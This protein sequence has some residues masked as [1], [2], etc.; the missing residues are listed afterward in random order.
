MRITKKFTGESSIGKRVFHPC[1][2]EAA[3][4]K[5]RREIAE[6]ELAWRSKLEKQHLEQQTQASSSSSRGKH[7]SSS[8]SL[9]TASDDDDSRKRRL[10]AQ[11]ASQLETW[12]ERARRILETNAVELSD[13]D[14]VVADGEDLRAH[15]AQAGDEPRKQARFNVQDDEATN[16]LFDFLQSAHKGAR[17]RPS[18]NQRSTTS[19][20]PPA[21]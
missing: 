21:D 7:S 18:A 14:A 20:E 4:E 13:V 19:D 5:S 2:D 6:L 9:A 11:A 10:D 17:Q 8:A 16:L 1:D 15:L 12:L 3:V